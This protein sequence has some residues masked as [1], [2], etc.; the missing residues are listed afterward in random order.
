MAHLF[1]Y[2]L[3]AVSYTHLEVA[4]SRVMCVANLIRKISPLIG[5]IIKNSELNK[6]FAREFLK[7]LKDRFIKEQLPL[8]LIH[9]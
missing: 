5:P 9:I 3:E 4:R 8:S 1:K 6:R 7:D 2:G